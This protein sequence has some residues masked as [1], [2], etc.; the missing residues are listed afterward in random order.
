[1]TEEFFNSLT[2]GVVRNK[3]VAI[4]K[5]GAYIGRST[6]LRGGFPYKK[7]CVNE[8]IF[9][10]RSDGERLTQNI[11]Y[12]WLQ[13][14]KTVEY[15]RATNSNSAQPGINQGTLDKLRILLPTQELAGIFDHLVD[16]VFEEI[17]NLA[18]LNTNLRNTR[19]LLIP[20]L[21]TGRRKLK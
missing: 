14:Q 21:V 7:F 3:D 6:F 5:D 19:D 15:I 2:N 10:I 12:L 11:L 16:P 18:K 17:I 20:Q 9:L 13:N 4:Y 8:H 1:M